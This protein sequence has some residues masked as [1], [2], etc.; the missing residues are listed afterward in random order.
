MSDKVQP[1]QPMD[2]DELLQLLDGHTCTLPELYQPVDDLFARLQC[3][4]C[5]SQVEKVVDPHRPFIKQ[6]V[7]PNYIARCIVC[8]CE[9]TETGLIIKTGGLPKEG[10]NPDEGM[11]PVDPRNHFVAQQVID[12]F[13]KFNGSRRGPFD[14]P[15]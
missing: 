6:Q 10:P 11:S 4:K 12:D 2:E 3:P 7:V 13:V 15:E 1:L 9:F 8:G 14:G 5:G